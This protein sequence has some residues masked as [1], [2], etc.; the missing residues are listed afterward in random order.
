M[1]RRG[2]SRCRPPGTTPRRLRWPGWCPASGPVDARRRGRCLD[3]AG[4]R[5]GAARRAGDCRCPSGCIGCCCCATARRRAPVW[6]AASGTAPGFVLNLA[7]FHDAG[8]GFDAPAFAEAVETAV[9]ALT[10]AAPAAPRGSRSAWPISPVCWRCS[11]S[12]MARMRR[13]RSPARSPPSCAA[14]RRRRPARWRAC[15]APLRRR[16]WTGRR[17]RPTRRCRAWP[18]RRGPRGRP[19]RRQT[20]CATPR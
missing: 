5:A 4:G 18:R 17:R 14:G 9:T 12:S 16:R 6:Q 15:S 8:S 13:W 3:P 19:P 7:S 10:L 20:D 11:G 2:W 1:R